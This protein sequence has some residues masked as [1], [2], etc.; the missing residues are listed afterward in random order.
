MIFPPPPLIP[1]RWPASLIVFPF[2]CRLM[3]SREQSH[4]VPNA[5]L[6]YRTLHP[7]PTVHSSIHLEPTTHS[8]AIRFSSS[9]NASTTSSTFLRS[10]TALQPYCP[11]SPYLYFTTIVLLM[12]H[13]IFPLSICS[14]SSVL[15]CSILLA[16]LQSLTGAVAH[17]G[18]P[19]PSLHKPSPTHLL[20]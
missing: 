6:S 20:H 18:S 9:C 2:P 8:F 15:G 12:S 7:L 11:G 16:S 19:R 5:P 13:N 14:S 10:N 1:P 4:L 3:Q 17:V